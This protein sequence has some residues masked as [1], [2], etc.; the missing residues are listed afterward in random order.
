MREVII[1]TLGFAIKVFLEIGVVL[2][3]AYGI[4]NEEKLVAFERELGAVIRFA[5]IKYVLKTVPN[6]NRTN[7]RTNKEMSRMEV[8]NIEVPVHTVRL[9]RA[10]I[11]KFPA[12]GSQ[13]KHFSE[14]A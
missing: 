2:L 3:I 8:R 12:D 6:K 7:D 13:A 11:K 4:M 10:E 9:R 14:V 5:L 1:M